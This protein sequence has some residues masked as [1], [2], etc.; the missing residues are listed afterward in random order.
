LADILD[1]EK[2]KKRIS[3]TF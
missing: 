3:S 2:E 1:K